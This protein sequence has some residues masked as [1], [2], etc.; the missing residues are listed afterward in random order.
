[1]RNGELLEGR[2]VSW[3]VVV[4]H[5]ESVGGRV[6]MASWLVV[7]DGELVGVVCDGVS[8]LNIVRGDLVGRA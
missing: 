3:L 5:A 1:M 8:W 7:S 6:R 2:A 4:G